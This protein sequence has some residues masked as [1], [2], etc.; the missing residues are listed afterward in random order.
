MIILLSGPSGA[1][2]STLATMLSKKLPWLKRI[3]TFT[4]RKPRSGEKAG[5]D[6]NF[7]SEAEIKNL[8][9]NGDLIECTEVYNN[10]YGTPKAPLDQANSTTQHA[11]LVVDIQGLNLI[12]R[13]YPQFSFSI[14]LQPEKPEKLLKRLKRRK[15]AGGA[16][17]IAERL[18]HV[19]AEMSRG[20]ECDVVVTNWENA[21]AKTLADLLTVIEKRLSLHP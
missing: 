19:Q 6:Y 11:L 8:Y 20:S 5:V 15:N 17:A 12:K 3:I 4:S 7:V 14:W 13:H 10:F 9:Q 1:G 16:K 21:K 2:K 18:A